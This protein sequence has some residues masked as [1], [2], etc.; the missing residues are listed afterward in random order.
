MQNLNLTLLTLALLCLGLT[1]CHKTV[2]RDS[3]GNIY[4]TVVI[5]SQTW[6]AVNLKTTKYNDSSIIKLVSDSAC[7]SKLSTQAYCWYKIDEKSYKDTY[8]YLYNWY[9]VH[10]DKLCPFGWHVPTDEDFKILAAFLGGDSIAG[11]LLK[12]KGTGHWM[13]P[14]EGGE[15]KVGFRALPGGYRSTKG[16]CINIG[17]KGYFWASVPFDV[18]YAHDLTLTKDERIFYDYTN[19]KNNG[20]SVR[21]LKNK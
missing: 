21:C 20:F 4:E 2:V 10:T 5:G 15:D 13:Y 12:E 8:G 18:N 19:F 1:K 9:A 7:W 6:M 16:E 17:I 11:G 14:N 3:D